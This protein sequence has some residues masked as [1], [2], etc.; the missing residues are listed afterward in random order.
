MH[1]DIEQILELVAGA[2]ANLPVERMDVHRPGKWSIAQILEHLEKTFSST[3]H[4]LNRCVEHQQTKAKP[5]TFGQRVGAWVVVDLGHFP[6]GRRSPDV[7][8]P[9][10]MPAADVM[11]ALTTSLHRLDNAAALAEGMFGLRAKLANHPVLGA[12][13]VRQWRRFH[14]I[15]TRHHMKQIVALR[16]G[17]EQYSG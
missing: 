10:G 3:A 17:T 6:S 14:L 4:I 1:A 12:F 5:A 15:H 2:T 16:N 11:A 9:T 7:A 8:L 13:N